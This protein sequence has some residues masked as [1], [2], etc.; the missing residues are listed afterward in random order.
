[1]IYI[2][3][4]SI[5]LSTPFD[6]TDDICLYM[7]TWQGNVI[8]RTIDTRNLKMM[9]GFNQYGHYIATMENLYVGNRNEVLEQ[10]RRDVCPNDFI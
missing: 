1:M 3:A 4:I 2:L 7:S 9:Q 8:Y 10:F 6:H 5:F